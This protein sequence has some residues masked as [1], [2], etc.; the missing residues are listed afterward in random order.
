MTR[1]IL[2]TQSRPNGIIK[3]CFEQ[4][5]HIPPG[6]SDYLS[7]EQ[8]LRPTLEEAMELWR[9]RGLNWDKNMFKFDFAKDDS[10]LC[11]DSEE[12]RLNR[13]NY[14]VIRFDPE[15]KIMDSS[16]GMQ[17]KASHDVLN[18]K[19]N[20]FDLGP[21]MTLS[22]SGDRGGGQWVTAFA[23]ELGHTL[24]LYHEQQN[25]AWWRF[26][27]YG[28]DIVDD[29]KPGFGPHTFICSELHD[30]DKLNATI[31]A[32]AEKDE[33]P[34]FSR[35]RRDLRIR[36]AC[37]QIDMARAYG[38]S[39]SAY[40]PE[41]QQALSNPRR[42]EP[43]YKSIMIYPSRMNG[44]KLPGNSKRNIV[45]KRWDGGEIQYNLAPSLDDIEAIRKLYNVR[46]MTADE[47][48]KLWLGDRTSA[49]KSKFDKVFKKGNC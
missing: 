42:T 43:D 19:K 30:Y 14:L 49:F 26:E 12:N 39:A 6:G 35:P 47:R 37:T 24:G 8:I 28:G 40:L 5:A 48:G 3:A 46:E 45:F 17:G 41:F 15:G 23:H 20:W 44:K 21:R 29:D 25:P 32:A 4:K 18:K 31:T 11:V 22:M 9:T 33:G 13:H 1:V 27:T 10:N 2:L 36:E 16:V 34:N 7:T 38:F